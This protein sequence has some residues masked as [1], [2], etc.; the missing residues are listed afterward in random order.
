M[1]RFINYAR[2]AILVEVTLHKPK[3]LLYGIRIWVD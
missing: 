1:L 3:I 2:T